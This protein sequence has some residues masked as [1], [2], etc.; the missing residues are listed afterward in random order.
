MML[1]GPVLSSI[2]FIAFNFLHCKYLRGGTLIL[3]GIGLGITRPA[4]VY[5]LSLSRKKEF[6]SSAGN[7]KAL[8][9]PISAVAPLLSVYVSN[10]SYVYIFSAIICLISIAFTTVHPYI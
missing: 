2:S 3:N 4:I 8:F 7:Y 10:F 6:Q 5:T 9:L 1:L